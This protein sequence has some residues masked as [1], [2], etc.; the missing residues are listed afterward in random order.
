MVVSGEEYEHDVIINLQ[1]LQ[2]APHGFQVLYLEEPQLFQD[3]NNE[4]NPTKPMIF[5]E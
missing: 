2:S 3:R 5:V 1:L 4:D